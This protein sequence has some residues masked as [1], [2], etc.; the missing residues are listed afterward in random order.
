MWRCTFFVHVCE[1]VSA[2]VRYT[3]VIFNNMNKYWWP[4]W[5][6]PYPLKIYIHNQSITS[7]YQ[8]ES[9]VMTIR[10]GNVFYC[11]MWSFF[12]LIICTQIF[13][14]YF[15]QRIVERNTSLKVSLLLSYTMYVIG[16]N[17]IRWQMSEEVKKENITLQMTVWGFC[18]CSVG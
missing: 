11:Y 13:N 8:S 12:K 6:P 5:F 15:I 17:Q 3:S 16:D 7:Y 14:Y 1:R 9:I 18:S 10:K 2:K 4:K